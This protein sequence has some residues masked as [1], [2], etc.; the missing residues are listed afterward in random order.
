MERRGPLLA[1]AV[2]TACVLV[3]AVQW[4]ADRVQRA[5]VLAL[6]PAERAALLQRTRENLDTLCGEPVLASQCEAQARLLL[7]LP[8]CDADCRLLAASHLPHATR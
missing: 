8:E 5:A 1:L 2:L 4:H 3:V 6:P 7:L